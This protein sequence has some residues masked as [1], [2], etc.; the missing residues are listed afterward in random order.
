MNMQ[1]WTKSKRLVNVKKNTKRHKKKQT[2]KQLKNPRS[3]QHEES[4]KTSLQ[5]EILNL[6]RPHPLQTKDLKLEIPNLNHK[7][8][9]LSN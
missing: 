2:R 3:D 4:H 7:L 5:V 9:L 8:L 1:K 6:K